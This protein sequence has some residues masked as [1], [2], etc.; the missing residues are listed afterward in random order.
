MVQHLKAISPHPASPLMANK[1]KTSVQDTVFQV[2]RAMPYEFP[3]SRITTLKI[4]PHDLDPVA[5][6]RD[7]LEMVLFQLLYRSLE[8]IGKKAGEIT[9]EFFEKKSPGRRNEPGRVLVLRVSD[10]GAPPDEG[11]LPGLLDSEFVMKH[12]R[13][14]GLLSLFVVRH[15]AELYD[16]KIWAEVSE[17]GSSIFVDFR[18]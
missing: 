12:D 4:I 2:L 3:M 17:R 10:N 15:V 7:H 5:M 8:A 9:I 6:E 14:G 16:G 13:R 11:Q 18:V 1:A